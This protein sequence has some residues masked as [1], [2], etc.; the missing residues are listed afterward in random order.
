MRAKVSRKLKNQSKS[1]KAMVYEELKNR[2]IHNLL[3]PG[4][5][6]N[7]GV[8]S[9]EFKISKTPIR[10]ALQQLEREGFIENIPVKGAF[11]SQLS[12]QDLRELFDLREILECEVIK[13]A[14]L[15]VD[16]EAVEALKEKF[17]SSE[18]HGKGSSTGGFKS[19]DEIHSFIFETYGN[20]RLLGIYKRIQDHIVR[21]RIH[22]FNH[23]SPSHP[24]RSEE[25]Y[26][27]HLE[28]LESLKA[29]DPL[30]AEQAMRNHLR[31]SMEYLKKVI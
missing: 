19:G 14:A 2:I 15:K 12:I 9:E 16:P 28:I 24:D 8:L 27:E 13:R 3:K 10:E 23:S 30:A 6:L 25:S 29:K 21:S 26:R 4:E 20:Q 5:P 18:N 11:V 1:K 31:N 7:E 22:F 17:V